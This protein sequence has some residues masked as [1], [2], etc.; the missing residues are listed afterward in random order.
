MTAFMLEI[1]AAAVL[2]EVIHILALRFGLS[3][4][5]WSV[6]FLRSAVLLAAISLIKP[7]PSRAALLLFG[8]ILVVIDHLTYR[9]FM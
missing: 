6:G 3:P 1:A 7:F 8:G 9:F 2:Y 5:S 4:K